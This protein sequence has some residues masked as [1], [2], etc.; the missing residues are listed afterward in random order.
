MNF[1]TL[2]MSAQPFILAVGR[3]ESPPLLSLAC[4]FLLV[5][6]RVSSYYAYAVPLHILLLFRLALIGW[7]DIWTIRMFPYQLRRLAFAQ[8][9]SCDD[10]RCDRRFVC[11]W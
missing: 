1:S 10:I 9:I 5:P 7:A 8:A 3:S 11:H 6:I 2:G 4:S